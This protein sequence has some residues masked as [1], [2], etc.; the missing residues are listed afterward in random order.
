M[1]LI[2]EMLDEI[3]R[4]AAKNSEEVLKSTG[5]LAE[6]EALRDLLRQ[7]GSQTEPSLV[8]APDLLVFYDRETDGSMRR[9]IAAADLE[10]ESETEIDK[11]K[12]APN[13][14]TVELRIKGLTCTIWLCN[15]PI[16][17]A[18]AA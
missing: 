14:R 4:E 10:I 6:A 11:T 13:C 3:E 8:S 1:S 12:N 7:H 9:A 2:Q 18:E 5:I 15:E 17:L 16:Q